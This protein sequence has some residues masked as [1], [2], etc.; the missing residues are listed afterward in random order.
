[1][2]G[3]KTERSAAGHKTAP[4]RP[5]DWVPPVRVI[6]PGGN[7]GVQSEVRVGSY[8][9]FRQ[10]QTD[11]EKSAVTAY[12]AAVKA[13]AKAVPNDRKAEGAVAVTYRRLVQLGLRPQVRGRYRP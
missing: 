2:A 4:R 9:G 11:A 1:M 3:V 12:D 6:R 5:K 7:P 8:W 13:L 10:P